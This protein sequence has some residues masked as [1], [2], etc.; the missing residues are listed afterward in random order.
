MSVEPFVEIAPI[1]FIPV[2][3]PKVVED[4]VNYNFALLI[5]LG[6][7]AII[8][9]SFDRSFLDWIYR[10]I[11]GHIWFGL[12][13]VGLLRDLH[14]GLLASTIR[15]IVVV[16]TSW[17]G[18]LVCALPFVVFGHRDDLFDYGGNRLALLDDDL[19]RL[20]VILIGSFV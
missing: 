1:T 11:L 9:W 5:S 15:R 20:L 13:I 17:L 8:F 18:F 6:I 2:L 10:G 7:N 12:W 14:S 4:V 16:P 3:V 19:R